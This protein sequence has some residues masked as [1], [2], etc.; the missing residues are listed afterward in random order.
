MLNIRRGAAEPLYSDRRLGG[1]VVA[2]SLKTAR[3]HF[4]FT[5]F[6][7]NQKRRTLL[8][9]KSYLHENYVTRNL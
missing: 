1:S 7:M 2:V 3:L 8:E 6:E 5:L 9:K 4:S